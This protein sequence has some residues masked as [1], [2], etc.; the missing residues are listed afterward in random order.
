MFEIGNE[1]ADGLNLVGS[2]L[3]LITAGNEESVSATPHQGGKAMVGEETRVTDLAEAVAGGF[4]DKGNE[5]GALEHKVR[6][7]VGENELNA[8]IGKALQFTQHDYIL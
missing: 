6:T 5:T 8:R 4:L 7:D 1:P 2:G 3:E